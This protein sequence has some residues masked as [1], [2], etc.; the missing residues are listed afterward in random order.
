MLKNKVFRICLL[1]SL[2]LALFTG[3]FA[4][5]GLGRFLPAVGASI[6][7]PFQ[8]A[9]STVGDAFSG[10]ASHFRDTDALQK[11]LD[12]LR[13]ENE[14]LRAKLTDAQILADEH[15]WLYAYLSMKEEHNDYTTLAASVITSVSSDSDGGE[16]IVEMTLN[17][18]ASSGVR[19]GMPVVC[20]EGLVGLVTEVG[21]TFCRVRTILHTDASVGAATTRAGVTGLCEGD[22]TA[23]HSGQMILRYMEAEADVLE[24]DIIVT[25][26]R[27]SVYPY[28]IPIGRVT[29]IS[30]NAFSRTTEATILPFADMTELKT[31][32]ILTSYEKTTE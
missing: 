26:G 16:Y 5:L 22:Y 12:S 15:S 29:G 11:E 30:S 27:G 25:S 23:L 19:T 7:Y 31:L 24:D 2:C 20:V 10:F 4:V 21:P 3:T 28:G 8:W 14:S 6:L 13:A 17:K 32:L 1:V 9:A 18:G